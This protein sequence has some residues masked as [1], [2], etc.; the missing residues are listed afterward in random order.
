MN[1]NSI[2]AR[3]VFD[4]RGH[5]TICVTANT[6]KQ[7]GTFIAP[8]DKQQSQHEP[9][10]RHDEKRYQGL[11]VL[12]P[13]QSINNKINDELKE[14]DQMNQSKI[15]EKLTQLATENG[16]SGIGANT[17]LA[18]S[19]AILRCTDTELFKRFGSMF[20]KKQ[21]T[22]PIPEAVMVGGGQ[23]TNNQLDI[24]AIT[25]VPTPNKNRTLSDTMELIWSIYMTIKGILK[26]DN[27][28]TLTAKNGGIGSIHNIETALDV[29]T[30]SIEKTD[31]S[32]SRDVKIGLNIG[33]DRLLNNNG[34]YSING[35]AF[36][37]AN[38]FDWYNQLISNYE[39]GH[40]CDPISDSDPKGWGRL[41]HQLPDHVKLVSKN[42]TASTPERI[43]K[44]ENI[45]DRVVIQLSHV[46][47]ITRAIE[48]IK[49]AH[50]LNK[51]VV[52]GSSLGATTDT[53]ITDLAVGG[54]ADYL[55]AGAIDRGERIV[56]YNRIQ[57]IA[58]RT[59]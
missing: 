1:I 15:D 42:L 32:T 16:V 34:E 13:I 29:I 4:N 33:A 22:V 43:Q 37:K 50:A 19:G 27:A 48:A 41:K 58:S 51:E 26:Q 57:A 7:Q 8:S 11:G 49:K 6:D 38:L 45:Y 23:Y 5:P 52:I 55:R 59:Q 53:T 10:K 56:K 46:K 30:Q 54:K 9:Y 28:L 20:N 2:E 18:V 35:R 31:Y 25:I 21:V 12:G 36:N 39:I 14:V 40:L 3:E 17:T 24:N 47:T 44:L